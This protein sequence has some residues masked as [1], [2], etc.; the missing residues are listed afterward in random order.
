MDAINFSNPNGFP[1]EADATLGFMQNN[2]VTSSRGLAAAFGDYTIVSGLEPNGS[3]VTD[4]W[5]YIGGDLVFFQGGAVVSTFYI[6]T[7]VVPKAN[8]NGVLY[9]RYYTKRAKFG[10]HPTLPN[11]TFSSLKRITNQ[12]LFQAAMVQALRLENE[13]II[14]GCVVSVN[15]ITTLFSVTEG[16]V[17]LDG[18][19]VATPS[20]SD[21]PLTQ[22]LVIDPTSANAAKWVSSLP[23]DPHIA[24]SSG[25]TSQYYVDIIKRKSAYFGEIR[26]VATKSS[27]FDATGLGLFSMRG[28]AIC[29]GSNGTYNMSGR[30]PIGLGSSPYDLLNNQGGS[31][32]VTLS[33][34]NMP[35]HNHS[36]DNTDNPTNGGEFGLMRRSITGEPKTIANSVDAQGSGVEADLITAPRRVQMQGNGE[37]FTTISPYI[38]V[39]LIQR[40]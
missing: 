34:A 25:G 23:S 31:E 5:L 2:Y 18:K 24:F 10:T 11:Y 35:A 7:T 37:P 26:M 39:L 29:N 16:L 1:L 4:G 28:W 13:V 33:L 22:Y 30:M 40:V 32:S 36:A 38:V 14:T 15:Q 3:A 17:I 12:L 9:D 19:L 27:D 21:A 20:L 6:E 8:E